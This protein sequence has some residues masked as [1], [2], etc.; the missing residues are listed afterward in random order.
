M[1]KRDSEGG[2]H[3]ETFVH[4][5]FEK[6]FFSP[7][8][9]AEFCKA[10]LDHALTDPI[11]GELGKSIV[12]CVS[13][14]HARKVAEILN[15]MAHARWPGRYQSDFAVQVTS[16][17]QGA[18]QMT[19]NFANNVLLGNSPVLTGYRTSKARV[20]V[21][22][23]MMT[24]GYDCEDL[25]NVVL[26]RP[27]FSPSDFVQMKGR[28]TRKWTFSHSERDERGNTETVSR[29][30]EAFKLFDFFANCEYFEEKF[31][32]DAKLSVVVP[33][34]EP[35]AGRDFIGGTGKYHKHLAADPITSF[36]SKA[37]GAQGMKIDREMFRDRFEQRIQG[38][39]DI[40][41]Y[42]Q[43]GNWD[44]V[45]HYIQSE[46]LDKPEEFF[47]L[48]KLRKAYTVDRKLSL[49]EVVEKIFG[50]IARFKLKDEL[51]EEEFQK[52]VSIHPPAEE[53]NITALRHFFKA[54]VVDQDVREIVKQKS[55]QRLANHP[56]LTMEEFKAITPNSR[57]LV[58]DYVD[59]YVKLDQFAA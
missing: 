8:T 18:Q 52:F 19:V 55:F 35:G 25:L 59:T 24:T 43:A 23:G 22:V 20:C 33:K 32:Y 34:D 57:S 29:P 21:T 46:V 10:F 26:M 45:L 7:E 12:F 1:V 9:N 42:V 28:G 14:S 3:E 11:N 17:V 4:R 6:K 36:E 41:R 27:I 31:N 50:I 49:R 54:Y 38:D 15:E 16:L 37:V 56:A 30:K 51:L 48:E 39:A 44:Q 58:P 47:T 2:E 53:E 13:Q 5:D 40:R